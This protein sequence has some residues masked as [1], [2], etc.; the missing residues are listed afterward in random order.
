MAI[1]RPFRDYDE[2]DVIN[3]FALL[4]PPVAITSWDTRV[5][6]GSLVGLSAKGWHNDDSIHD[7]DQTMNAAGDYSVN[8]VT[9]TRWEHT[10]EITLAGAA[11]GAGVLGMLLNHVALFDENG[12]RLD[13]NPRKASEL[14]AVLPWQA[15][16]VVRRGI[17]LLSGSDL[18]GETFDAGQALTSSSSTAGEWEAATAGT[19]SEVHVGYTLGNNHGTAGNADNHTEHLILLDVGGPSNSGGAHS[20]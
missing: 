4:N 13:Y 12:E 18:D 3:L 1:L 8:N 11:N 9:S 10:A 19:T 16:P 14:E 6:A 17:F 5:T 20:A 2:K 7:V 15:V